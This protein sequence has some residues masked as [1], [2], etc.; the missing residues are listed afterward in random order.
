MKNEKSRTPNAELIFPFAENI[1]MAGDVLNMDQEEHTSYLSHPESNPELK[2]NFR[3][4]LYFQSK[5][6]LLN[7]DPDENDM[8]KL[9]QEMIRNVL[10]SRER[11]GFHRPVQHST[12]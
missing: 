12:Y 5:G 8:E 2:K 7:F 10:T 3:I 11:E 6:I 9:Y 4:R 1:Q